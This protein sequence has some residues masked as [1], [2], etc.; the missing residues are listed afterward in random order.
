MAEPP[1]VPTW[2]QIQAMALVNGWFEGVP[3]PVEGLSVQLEDRYPMRHH[4]EPLLN[5][6]DVPLRACSISEEDEQTHIRNRWLSED[7]NREIILAQRGKKVV[8]LTVPF[9]QSATMLL[10]TL[11]AARGWT[12]E[13]EE[14]AMGK[15]R[16]LLTPYAYGCYAMTG[17]FLESSKRSRLT[18][19]FR[20]LRPTLALRA[21]E[22]EPVKILCALCLH[23]L[24]LYEGT[25][26]GTMVPTDDVIAHLLLMRGDEAR[27]WRQA[28]QHEPHQKAAGIF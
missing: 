8:A 17:M 25:W 1:A 6:R 13:A 2:E 15:L 21:R 9:N 10:D 26:A 4:L 3:C 24:G 23:P 27:F 11:G 12:L 22:G 7:G 18:Y 16:E 5:R 14:K 19:M 28:N 20:R